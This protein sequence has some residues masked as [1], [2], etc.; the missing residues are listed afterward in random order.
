MA[1]R[2]NAPHKTRVLPGPS[3]MTLAA[4]DGDIVRGDL[5]TATQLGSKHSA[6]G[7][8]YTHTDSEREDSA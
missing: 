8:V 7:V 5:S 2:K 4:K 3:F 1:G 6:D